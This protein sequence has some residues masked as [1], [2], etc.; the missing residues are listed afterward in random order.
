MLFRYLF[1]GVALGAC[2]LAKPTYSIVDIDDSQ[3]VTVRKCYISTNDDN[4]ALK[5]GKVP[6]A[7][8]DADSPAVENILVEDC[9]IGDGLIT[10]G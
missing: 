7:D 2:V 8:Q 1:L 3:N 6:R 10:C 5:G 9:E 4:I